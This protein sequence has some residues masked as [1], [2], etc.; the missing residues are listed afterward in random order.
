MILKK[1]LSLTNLTKTQAL[2]IYK[3]IKV[4]M[5]DENKDLV[6]AALEMM[7]LGFEGFN[8]D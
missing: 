7:I 6:F 3:L 5:I 2:Y 8:N 4:I 1:L